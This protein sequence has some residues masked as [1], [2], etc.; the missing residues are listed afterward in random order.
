MDA[1]PARAQTETADGDALVQDQHRAPR[2]PDDHEVAWAW[3]PALA[4]D[5]PRSPRPVR[6][7]SALMVNFQGLFRLGFHLRVEHTLKWEPKCNSRIQFGAIE[8]FFE[9]YSTSIS[10]SGDIFNDGDGGVGQKRFLI[11][12]L[13]TRNTFVR[14]RPTQSIVKFTD[15]PLGSAGS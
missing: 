13:K 6:H 15:C 10:R 11:S 14:R 8:A 1:P 12:A 3:Q 4:P 2:R 5:A 9:S 7:E